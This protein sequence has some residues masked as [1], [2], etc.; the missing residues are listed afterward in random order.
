[1]VTHGR[2]VS[3]FR[4]QSYEV[5][6]HCPRRHVHAEPITDE[7]ASR[8]LHS[9]ITTTSS[10]RNLFYLVLL[11]KQAEF[12]VATDSESVFNFLAHS[13]NTVVGSE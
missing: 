7:D 4:D 3:S 11:D 9:V 2:S 8:L 6:E 1:M 13:F 5:L 10:C 12:V